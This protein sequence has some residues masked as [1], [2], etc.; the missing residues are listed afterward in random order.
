[1]HAV[2]VGHDEDAEPLQFRRA[3][4]SGAQTPRL[5]TGQGKIRCAVGIAVEV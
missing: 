3:R 5:D 4:E 1:M 2:R